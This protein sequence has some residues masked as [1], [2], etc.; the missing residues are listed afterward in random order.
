MFFQM[1]NISISRYI[2]ELSGYSFER[3]R[4]V[5][6]LTRAHVPLAVVSENFMR[7]SHRYTRP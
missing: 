3:I 6:I 2:I 1:Y 5:R 7:I 4:G